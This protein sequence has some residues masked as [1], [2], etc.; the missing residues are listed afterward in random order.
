MN[1]DQTAEQMFAAIVPA[2]TKS[3]GNFKMRE[4]ETLVLHGVPTMAVLF[5]FRRSGI[6]L[7]D[8]WT[9]RAVGRVACQLEVAGREQDLLADLSSVVA[10]LTNLRLSSLR[11]ASTS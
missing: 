8:L 9:M 4:S 2:L 6:D 5:D 11:P 1:I 7:V 3:Y 10:V